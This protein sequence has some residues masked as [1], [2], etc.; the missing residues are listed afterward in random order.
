V[1]ALGRWELVLL[2]CLHLAPKPRFRRPCPQLALIGNE[3]LPYSQ[4]AAGQGDGGGTF[5][6]PVLRTQGGGRNTWWGN[7]K[8]RY[9][10]LEEWP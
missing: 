9:K 5:R 1:V 6:L 4:W 8:N 7:K 10:V 3:E 2:L